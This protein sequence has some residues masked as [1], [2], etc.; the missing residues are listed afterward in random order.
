MG[1][2]CVAIWLSPWL[3]AKCYYAERHCNGKLAVYSLL[4]LLNKHCHHCLVKLTFQTSSPLAVGSIL[5]GLF[6]QIVTLAIDIWRIVAAL[7]W[8][9]S[10][11]QTSVLCPFMVLSEFRLQ[12]TWKKRL[13]KKI[14]KVEIFLF[15]FQFR[16]DCKS[17]RAMTF[18]FVRLEGVTCTYFL[19]QWLD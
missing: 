2:L 18:F 14:E 3:Y 19:V 13:C 1:L 12:P 8:N 4:P 6:W 11:L 10:Q 17:K 9:S 16:D 5:A 15:F 7:S